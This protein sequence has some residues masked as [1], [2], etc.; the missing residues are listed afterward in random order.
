[1]YRVLAIY[2]DK[3]K[4]HR[5]QPPENKQRREKT[6]RVLL[7]FSFLPPSDGGM[8][9]KNILQLLLESNLLKKITL[10]KRR[11]S[12]VIGLVPSSFYPNKCCGRC[13]L[14]TVVVHSLFSAASCM[15]DS[16]LL[17]SRISPN[18]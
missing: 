5:V 11:V 2:N 18:I 6:K 15:R 13:Y 1:M 3:N 4:L 14:H 7:L 8:Y 17:R 9:D 10:R 12:T 16:M